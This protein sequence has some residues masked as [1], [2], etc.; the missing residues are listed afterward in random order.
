[1]ERYDLDLSQSLP[2]P[3]A[4]L[5]VDITSVSFAEDRK[6][7]FELASVL[8]AEQFDALIDKFAASA[9]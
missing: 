4:G 1:L 9:I 8:T 7:M 2:D 3:F 5:A 6:L